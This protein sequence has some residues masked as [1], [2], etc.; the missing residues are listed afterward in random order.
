M[1]TLTLLRIALAAR[2]ITAG[3]FA[4]SLDPP[5]SESMVYAVA[6][7]R[8]R[9]TRVRAAIDRL[10]DAERPRVALAFDNRRL[11]A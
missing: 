4:Q 7:G 8:K 11:A 3:G 5:V 10:I 1:D 2:G 6:A 9:S